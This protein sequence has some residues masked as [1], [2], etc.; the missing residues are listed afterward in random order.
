MTEEFNGIVDNSMLSDYKKCPRYFYH[1]HLEHLAVLDPMSEYKQCFGSAFHLGLE[2][3]YE[4]IKNGID[5]L[6]EDLRTK[7]VNDAK[8]LFN[9][10]EGADQYG[11]CTLERLEVYLRLYFVRFQK[12]NFKVIETE[13][14]GS[15]TFDGITVIFKADM[16]IEDTFGLCVFE[17]KT[18]GRR[19]Y[20][21]VEPNSQLDTYISGVRVNTGEDVERAMF[22]QIYYRKG[23]KKEMVTDTVD[24]VRE[25]TTRTPAKLDEWKKDT[26]FYSNMIKE[27]SKNN[28]WPKNPNNCTAYGGCM[29]TR[30]C[31]QTDPGI[32]D[33]LKRS[34]YSIRKWEP[35]EGARG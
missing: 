10:F 24:F 35:W 8:E 20:L 17:T 33:T 13:I 2:I 18:S 31:C 16:L 34:L 26:V 28:Y 30:L 22:N 14:G 5:P 27:S 3:W 15:F 12:E 11:V 1:R 7:A 6:D 32:K 4:G 19:G 25:E 21:I 9:N 29:F 23:T